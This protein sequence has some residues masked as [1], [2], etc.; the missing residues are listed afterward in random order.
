MADPGFPVQG[1]GPIRGAV[2]LR[3][4]HFSVK[5]YP[6]MKEL[7]PVGGHALGMPPRSANVRVNSLISVVS[8]SKVW[9]FE[10]PKV[11]TC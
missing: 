1:C 7:G 11:R 2:D 6:K 9:I 3:C 8:G 5:M 4:R 10:R